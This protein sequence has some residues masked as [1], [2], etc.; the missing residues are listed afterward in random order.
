M[1]WTAYRQ[2][3][4]GLAPPLPFPGVAAGKLRPWQRWRPIEQATMA[5]GYGL[6]TSLLQM[7]QAYTALAGDG[8]VR[9]VALI[10]ADETAPPAST[11]AAPVRVTTESTAAHMRTMLEAATLTGG[12]GGAARVEGYRVGGK[13]GTAWKHAG[14]GYAKNKY[15]SLFVG[16]APID[17]P[18]LV[19]AVMIDDPSS[20]SYYGGAV[21]GPVFSAVAGGALQLLGVPPS[22]QTVST[23]SA[24]STVSSPDT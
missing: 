7:A 5:Y 12:T 2:Y 10:G 19:V 15:R 14:T 1:L 13:T 9:P 8:M 11:P 22:L 6:S 4:I 17:S 18:R 20:H 23:L 24:A 21:A 3:G 16:I